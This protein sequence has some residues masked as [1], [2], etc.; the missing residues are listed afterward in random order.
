MNLTTTPKALS[1]DSFQSRTNRE[2][3]AMIWHKAYQ[4][5]SAGSNNYPFVYV[6]ISL[7]S[8]NWKD[9]LVQK[10]F[11]TTHMYVPYTQTLTPPKHL[12]SKKSTHEMISIG[13]M[14]WPYI[15]QQTS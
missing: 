6:P 13:G 3:D 7:F 14:I 12:Y 4:S 11:P 1:W 10:T 5:L 9:G 2:K 8:F 15:S